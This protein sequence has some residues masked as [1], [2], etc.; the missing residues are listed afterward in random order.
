MAT[1]P[2]LDAWPGLGREE[3]FLLDNKG[4]FWYPTEMGQGVTT[5]NRAVPSIKTPSV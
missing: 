1:F 3:A 5:G 4:N 2:T